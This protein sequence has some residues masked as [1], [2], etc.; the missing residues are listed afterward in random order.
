M[1]N[2][3][4][5]QKGVTLIEVVLVMIC[6]M[7]L[8]VIINDIPP[9]ISSIN[10]SRHQD[11]AKNIVDKE[12]ETLRKQG[13]ANLANGLVNF[14]DPNLTQLTTPTATVDIENCPSNIC[15]LSEKIK[16]VVVTVT[17]H[18]SGAIK[19]VQGTTLIGEGG[20]N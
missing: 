2:I 18:E 7:F 5:N 15:T 13:Y 12:L 11:I 1:I 10:K 9:S 20:L 8:I 14:S 6:V 4:F 3:K 17:W 16:N 19:N